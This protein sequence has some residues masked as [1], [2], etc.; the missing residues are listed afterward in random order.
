[1]I[2]RKLALES[3]F[4]YCSE[5]NFN[6]TAE[7]QPLVEVVSVFD[8]NICSSVLN[9]KDVDQKAKELDAVTLMQYH[10]A[11]YVGGTTNFILIYKIYFEIFAEIKF[12]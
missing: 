2:S 3:E 1:M 8:M 12:Y 9:D 6:R 10:A 5:E 4:F 7:A 11:I